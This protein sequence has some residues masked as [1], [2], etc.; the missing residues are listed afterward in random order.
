MKAENWTPDRLG[1]MQVD[2]M[3]RLSGT[4]PDG[5]RI[6]LRFKTKREADLEKS[7]I[8][9]EVG[10]TYIQ[11]ATQLT[12]EEENDYKEAMS[13]LE[14]ADNIPEGFT[15]KDAM[16]FA[17]Q[18]YR[19]SLDG[20][21]TIKEVA[22]EWLAELVGLRRTEKHIK[23]NKRVADWLAA[24]FGEDKPVCELT[25]EDMRKFLTTDK[26]GLG[27]HAGKPDISWWSLKG[28]RTRTASFF[29][30]ALQ[31]KY[32]MEN[33]VDH[34]IKLPEHVVDEI[35]ILT[36]SEVE[37]LFDACL[38]V[39]PELTIPYF[40][41]ATFAGIRPEEICPQSKNN[42]LTWDKVIVREQGKSTVEVAAKVGKTR[43]RRV[44]ELT[45][46][47]VEWLKPYMK[48]SG[49]IITLDYRDWRA[50]FDAVRIKAGYKVGTAEARRFDNSLVKK[51]KE[52]DKKWVQ[53]ICRHTAITYYLVRV[54][55]NEYQAAAWAGNSPEVIQEHYDAKVTGSIE[56]TPEEQYEEF[57]AI[58]PKIKLVA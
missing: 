10:N 54:G 27:P 35:Q 8:L 23:D 38:E 37:E 19:V 53:D 42:K 30:F 16:I 7:R 52:N 33:P 34:S 3:W 43:R 46:N 9:V 41:L 20:S 47:C 25:T 15:I 45:P 13:I 31:R 14:G 21:K 44:V 18:H 1:I 55:N 11:R 58:E 49:P 24:A 29:K 5:K 56:Q 2:K 51:A 28:W 26:S 40:A 4:L 22:K 6:R 48:A 12:L 57:Y 39:R 36:N 50:L 32:V 17:R